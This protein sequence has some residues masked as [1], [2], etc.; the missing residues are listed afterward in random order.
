MTPGAAD[1]TVSRKFLT[2][3]NLLS[4][5]RAVLT[6]PFMLCMLSDFPGSR[7]WAFGI[8]VAALLTDKLDGDLARWLHQETEW[9]R[10]LDP[11]ADKVGL[12][13]G[14]IA[15]LVLGILPA[16]Y[17]I[18]LIARDLLIFSGGMY[19]K[20]K[21]GVILPSNLTG[22]WAVGAIALTFGLAL[23]GAPE[24]GILISLWASVVM[25][26]ISLALYVRRF[27]GVLAEAR[28]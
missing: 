7:T 8:F 22:K 9:G 26:V 18:A 23:L 20:M 13:A 10:I 24:A 28:S 12:G 3:S 2:V 25:L 17:V 1:A 11:L 4:I 27:L 16:W 14:A 6:I 5:T 19:L 15:F 21:R